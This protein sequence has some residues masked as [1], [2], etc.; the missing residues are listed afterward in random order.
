MAHAPSLDCLPRKTLIALATNGSP[1][2]KRRVYREQAR[3]LGVRHVHELIAEGSSA[4]LVENAFSSLVFLGAT[5][6]EFRGMSDAGLSDG[7][8]V[9]VADWLTARSREEGSSIA[10]EIRTYLGE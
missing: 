8:F 7:E 5:P 3:R 1:D 9:A 10:R 2:V 4:S 6:S